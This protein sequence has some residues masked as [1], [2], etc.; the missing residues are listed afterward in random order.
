MNWFYFFKFS[1]LSQGDIDL[2]PLERTKHPFLGF[3]QNTLFTFCVKCNKLPPIHGEGCLTAGEH[4]EIL[5]A[6]KK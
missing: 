1:L 3:L 5:L 6:V 4:P 2:A